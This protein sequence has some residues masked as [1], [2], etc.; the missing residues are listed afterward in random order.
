MGHITFRFIVLALLLALIPAGA[1]AKELQISKAPIN[2]AFEQYVAQKE[3]GLRRAMTPEGHS[4]GYVPPLQPWLTAKEK[5]PVDAVF[6]LN[7]AVAAYYPVSFDLRTTNK[8]TAIKDQN[9][10]GSC[11]AF[12]SYA[13]AESFR[14]PRF[15]EPDFSEKHLV[16]NHGFDW[17]PCG[18]GFELMTL[19]YL[20][21][22]DGPVAESNCYYNYSARWTNCGV[23]KPVKHHVQNA[24]YFDFDMDK[25][26][27]FLT[28]SD[29]G[30]ISSSFYSNNSFYNAAHAAYYYDGSLGNA[31]NHAV[32]IIGWDDDYPGTNFNRTPPGNGAFL[33]K[34]SWGSG[35]GDNGYFWVS[36][37]DALFGTQNWAFYR[38]EWTGNYDRNYQYDTLGWVNTWACP[39]GYPTWGANIFTAKANERLKAISFYTAQPNQTVRYQVYVNVTAGDPT[40]GTIKVNKLIFFANV[41]YHT[42]KLSSAIALSKNKKFAVVLKYTPQW[43][44][45]WTD[46]VLPT[47]ARL[48]GYSSGATAGALESFVSCDG[49]SWEDMGATYQ[50]NVAIKAFTR[51]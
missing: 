30:A 18:G 3:L 40:S 15:S 4:F 42:V 5:H 19:A 38:A 8:V 36:Y 1:A 32:A 7:R 25:I 6:A 27:E 13:S 17:G 33:V 14:M 41:G 12:S 44:G 34:N 10:C 35:W 45:L 48:M 21:R 47:E 16:W 20:A 37:Y 49:K 39:N 51:S 43:S 28:R 22:W 31:S 9:Q 24:E 29:G 23:S 2:P 50:E 26:K 11:W 46:F